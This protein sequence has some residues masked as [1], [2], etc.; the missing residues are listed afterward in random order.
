MAAVERGVLSLEELRACGMDNQAVSVRVRNG[1]LHRIHRGVYA[2]GH[3]RLTVDSAFAAAVK[4][5]APH[6]ALSHY[7][8]AALRAYLKWDFRSVEVT[9]FGGR[10]I[11][12]PGLR[13]HRSA[14]LEKGDVTRVKGIPVT[15]PALTLL[16]LASVVDDKTLRRA[17]SQAL[18]LR[19]V[20]VGQLAE[21][22]ARRRPRRGIAKLAK[23]LAT[24]PAPTRT[25]L[26]DRVFALLIDGG[27]ERPEVNQPLW[28]SGRKV[29]PDFRW[30]AQHLVVE[31]DGAAWHDQKLAR[32]DDAERQAWLEA[33]GEQVVRVTWDQAVLAP[34][35]TL[36]RVLNYGAPLAESPVGTPEA[37]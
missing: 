20:S 31:A 15:S 16:D 2:V 13:V 5:C 7:A 22:V 36:R 4:T 8:A 3:A 29:V 34:C 30:P 10:H 32:E 25:E 17:V 28:L 6:A 27:L 9:I 11:E 23:L 19:D 14:D 18:S 21:A 24:G 37:D 12:R 26:E 1:Q 35:Q 33:H